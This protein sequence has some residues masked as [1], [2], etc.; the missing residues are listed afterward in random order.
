MGRNGL[1]VN[2]GEALVAREVHQHRD[3]GH[4]DGGEGASTVGRTGLD[5]NGGEALVARGVHQ[6][7][8]QG[9]GD[10]GEGVHQPQAGQGLQLDRADGQHGRGG[11]EQLPRVI[12]KRKVRLR[13]GVIR[14]GRLQ[15]SI[16]NFVSKSGEGGNSST[17]K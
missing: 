2:T 1:D 6:H 4:G 16:V 3:Q 14:D 12:V 8:D 15:L 5:D 13:D 9:H 7:G 11:G 17:N 10:G